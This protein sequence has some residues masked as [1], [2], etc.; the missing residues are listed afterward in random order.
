MFG[1]MLA[2]SGRDLGIYGFSAGLI[3]AIGGTVGLYRESA[4]SLP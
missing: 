3:D 4:S 2:L 1:F